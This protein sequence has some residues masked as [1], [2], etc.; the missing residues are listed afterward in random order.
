MTEIKFNNDTGEFNGELSDKDVYDI[1]VKSN[2][3]TENMLSFEEFL[4][5]RDFLD[6]G[7]SEEEAFN[8]AK[9]FGISQKYRQS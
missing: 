8:L 5:L 4:V 2:I 6:A 9:G 7:Y 3:I 1:L